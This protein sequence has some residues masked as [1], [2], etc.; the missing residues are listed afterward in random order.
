LGM[1]VGSVLM[2]TVVTSV[3]AS[4]LVNRL[5]ATELLRDE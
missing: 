5:R 2:A 1:V 3:V 4:S